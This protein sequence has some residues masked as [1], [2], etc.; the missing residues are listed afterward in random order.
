MSVLGGVTFL[1]GKTVI[2]NLN[3]DVINSAKIS[4]QENI[5]TLLDTIAPTFPN[6]NIIFIIIPE[7]LI[8]FIV[9]NLIYDNF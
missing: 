9:F 7:M 6:I 4:A 3:E 5:S 2:D 8:M 1:V